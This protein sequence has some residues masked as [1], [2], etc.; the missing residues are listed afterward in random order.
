M[1]HFIN[2]FPQPNS[3]KNKYKEGEIVYERVRPTQ[4]LLIRRCADGVYYCNVEESHTKKEL[5][6][7]ERDIKSL[8]LDNA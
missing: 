1:N 8:L 6:F 3:M 5:V 7:L 2:S 4:K